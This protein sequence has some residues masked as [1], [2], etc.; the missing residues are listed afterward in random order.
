MIKR[1]LAYTIMVAVSFLSCTGDE[2]LNPNGPRLL[3]TINWV[4]GG[5]EVF[6]DGVTNVVVEVAVAGGKTFRDSVAFYFRS[7]AIGPV[8]DNSTV[9]VVIR[10]LDQKGT[11][12]FEGRREGVQVAQENVKVSISANELTPNPPDTV[13]ALAVGSAIRLD[14]KGGGT[15]RTRFV[16][17]RRLIGKNSLDPQQFDNTHILH[18]DSIPA[19]SFTVLDTAGMRAGRT[20]SYRIYTANSVGISRLFKACTAAVAPD[21]FTVAFLGNRG[22]DDRFELRIEEGAAITDTTL[23]RRGYTPAG[24]FT[25]IN[26]GERWNF[27][28]PLASDTVLYA[29]WTEN[30]H[31]LTFLAAGGTTP[32]PLTKEIAF[33][34]AYGE[35]ATTSR[36]GY[37]FDYWCT[38]ATESCSVIVETTIVSRDENHSLYARWSANEYRVTF[39]ARGG[40]TP[41]PVN[42][43]VTYDELYGTLAETS[44]AGH[45]FR[46]WY[47]QAS[48][49]AEITAETTVQITEDD[50]LYAQWSGPG[51]YKITYILNGGT[52]HGDNPAFYTV[53]TDTVVFG[54]PTRTGYE[55]VGWYE[56]QSGTSAIREIPQ[57]STGVK[58]LYARWRANEY[59][60]TF[61]SRGGA[62]PDPESR[63]VTYDGVYDPLAATSWAGYS[64]I[65]WF[66]ETNGG[67]NIVPGTTVQITEDDT[68]FAR[69]S[70]PIEYNINYNLNGG[71][72]HGDNPAFYTVETETVVFGEPTRTGYKFEG[73][74]KDSHGTHPI[75]EIPQGSTGE[76]T[77]WAI[78]TPNNYTVFFDAQGGSTPYPERNQVEYDLNY[79]QLAETS[80]LGY[81]LTGWFTEPNGG[82]RVTEGTV[83]QIT[84]DQTLYA[85]WSEPIDYYIIYNLDNGTNHGD[86]PAF[87]TVETDTIVFQEASRTGYEFDGWYEATDS[88]NAI[89][90]IPQGS[91][92]ERVLNARWR[93]N[94]YTVTFDA[95]GGATAE[96][97]IRQITYDQPFDSLAMTSRSGY[98]FMGWFTE[99]T[100]GIEVTENTV[101]QKTE[102]QTLYARWSGPVEYAVTY[103]L[104]NGTNHSSNPS[105]Y[106]VEAENIIT[107]ERPTKTDW[108]FEGWYAEESFSTEITQIPLGSTGSVT[109]YAKWRWNGPD[110]QDG[111]GNTYTTVQIGNQVWTVENLRT[112]RYTDGTEIAG[113]SFP[114]DHWGGLAIPAYCWYQNDSTRGYGP[115]YNWWVVNPD[116][117]KSV[118]PD[119]WRVPADED[120]RVLSDHLGGMYMDG[121]KMKAEEGYVEFGNGTNE[122][123]FTGFPGG[124]RRIDGSFDN[125][126]ITGH[127]WTTTV[128]AN[129]EALYYS[130]NRQQDY[131]NSTYIGKQMGF[132]VR[133][134][135][136]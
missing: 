68:L 94:R 27:E 39:D 128:N 23:Q 123:G 54:E 45:T 81:T 38:D 70:E 60:V 106:T 108:V 105:F 2:I 58:T 25:D 118:A 104:F 132:S 136:D 125:V 87:F 99:A 112:T 74:H 29:K 66:T 96:P 3:P 31:T 93:A 10:G 135:R 50:T 121:K 63:R 44:K 57:G 134:V 46:G 37:T 91:I 65:G 48:G 92:G 28:T 32:S 56:D 127:W 67:V 113:P 42:R 120:W 62:T 18:L 51:E 19:D 95:Q 13:T 34:A 110:P 9:T 26:L 1:M 64:F 5:E 117:P 102:D 35:L 84:E 98:N 115:L 88:I 129:S 101:V 69:W 131:L 97:Q 41:D 124:Y 77:L 71:T 61:D 7:V 100:G 89:V 15:N 80:R 109:L 49:G 24:W 6:P 52:N 53:E 14:W 22:G 116:N 17:Y 76:K 114:N 82:V 33:D 16:L 107:F 40:A 8:P 85:R 73:W 11:V 133:L 86:N 47:T 83:V 126:G 72:N 20:F 55:F 4:S 122:S 111:N 21:T 79:F 103:N 12:L 90:K 130:L 75:R 36:D 59:W 43:L 78:W 119:G 30:R